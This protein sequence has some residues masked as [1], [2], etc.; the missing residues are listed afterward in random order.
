MELMSLLISR[1]S[2]LEMMPILTLVLCIYLWIF[3]SKEGE[4]V[5]IKRYYYYFIF[6]TIIITKKSI[7]VT[8]ILILLILQTG[9]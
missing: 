8:N 5:F 2:L 9:L 3:S 1:S 4:H 7:I 6:S